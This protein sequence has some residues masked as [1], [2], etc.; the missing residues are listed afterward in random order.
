M[1]FADSA[2]PG[3]VLDVDDGLDRADAAVQTEELIV[4]GSGQRHEFEDLVQ[5][6]EDAVRVTDVLAESQRAFLAQSAD[7]VDLGVFMTAPQQ[8]DMFRVLYLQRQQQAD[9]L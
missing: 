8:S 5:V 4:D 6:I 1:T 3:H 9:C 7:S 2:R